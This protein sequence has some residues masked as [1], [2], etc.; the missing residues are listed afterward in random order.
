M[1]TQLPS[2]KDAQ[3][4]NFRPCLLCPNGWMEQDTIWCGDRPRPRRHCARWG[5]SSPPPKKRAQPPIFGLYLLWPTAGWIKM[6]LGTKVGLGPGHIY[7]DPAHPQRGSAPNFWPMSIVSKRLPISATA[8]HLLPSI[9]KS[10]TD[11][12]ALPMFKIQHLST[13]TV[14]YQDC[15][16][17]SLMHSHCI[18]LVHVVTILN[19]KFHYTSWFGA[20]SKLVRTR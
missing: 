3:P 11:G 6:P 14:S 9:P 18:Q 13:D 15:V 2:L 19:A 12:F 20:G 5:P 4:S 1:G 16:P 10:I 8:K 17:N 7:G